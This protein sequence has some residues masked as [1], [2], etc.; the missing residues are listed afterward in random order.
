MRTPRRMA[1]AATG[2]TAAG[3][4]AAIAIALKPPSSPVQRRRFATCASTPAASSLK[5][6]AGADGRGAGRDEPPD[7][8]DRRV[9]RRVVDRHAAPHER[10]ARGAEARI[11]AAAAGE[12]QRARGAG[13]Q[14]CAA[15]D[16]RA[17]RC[18]TTVSTAPT[19]STRPRGRARAPSPRRDAGRQVEQHGEAS[20]SVCRG[21]CRRRSP[22]RRPRR[23]RSRPPRSSPRARRRAP[24]AARA[25]PRRGPDAPYA[26]PGRGARAAA[27]RPRPR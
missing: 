13:G 12:L 10:A 15:R 27:A 8:L 20:V 14:Q 4:K 7:V 2:S 24:R 5:V 21:G 3:S 23:A 17:T 18:C 25:A 22:P 11:R 19:S 1:A 16:H 6:T 26:R 9:Q